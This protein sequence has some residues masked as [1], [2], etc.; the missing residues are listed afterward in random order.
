MK[1]LATFTSAAVLALAAACPAFAADP[2]EPRS[3][4]VHFA[5]LDL[6][7]PEGA[8]TLMR[9]IRQ[10]AAQVCGR[11]GETPETK[12]RHRACIKFAVSNAV[13]AVDRPVVS[14]YLADAS[15]GAPAASPDK[16]GRTGG[17]CRSERC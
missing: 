2:Y 4:Q 16:G 15:S 13:A 7:S 17:V 10:A 6:D 14:E 11:P 3:I 12:M 5:D 8:A 1:N 9:R